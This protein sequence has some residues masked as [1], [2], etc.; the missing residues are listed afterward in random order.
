[1]AFLFS[2]CR[3]GKLF[4]RFPWQFAGTDLYSWVKKGT[5]RV[6]RFAQE[7]NMT[8][9]GLEPEPPDPESGTVTIRP[10]ALQECWEKLI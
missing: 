9:L 7:R 1:M 4:V 5:V 3:T 10:P 2:I 8:R 6:K